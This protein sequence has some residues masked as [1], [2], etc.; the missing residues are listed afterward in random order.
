MD[1]IS[2]LNIS[3]MF[4]NTLQ[5]ISSKGSD[6]N[7][8]MA[9]LANGE[10]LSNEQMISLQFEVGQYNT[11]MEALSTVTKSMTDMMKSLAQRSS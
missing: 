5:G 11:M 7:A 8:K 1:S 10:E 6:L 9:E 4:E 2:G 3:Q